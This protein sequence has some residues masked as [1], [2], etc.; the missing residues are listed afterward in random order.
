LVSFTPRQRQIGESAKTAETSNFKNTVGSLKRLIGRTLADP[1]VEEFEKKFINAELVD[2]AGG[3]GVKVSFLFVRAMAT[4]TGIWL[5]GTETDWAMERTA[6]MRNPC[7]QDRNAL[8]C[9]FAL[10]SDAV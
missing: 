1:E 5:N 4:R 6:I 7:R 8:D 2:V 9:P 10:P 3:L